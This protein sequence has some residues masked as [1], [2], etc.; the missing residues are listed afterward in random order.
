MKKQI[1]KVV[2]D[3]YEWPDRWKG[4]EE[5]K[6]YGE[7]L[8]KYFEPFVYQLAIS[9]LT[10]KTIKKHIDNLWLAGGELIREVSMNGEYGRSPL[11]LISANF[12][13]DGGPYCRH[14]E[15]VDELRAY[16]S[17]CRKFYKF[18]MASKV[19]Q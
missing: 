5:D 1:L 8:L 14:L 6:I 4:L 12:G 16:D 13:M 11:D 7:R 18:L 17:S 19:E 9:S 15:T 10:I 3:F 2:P